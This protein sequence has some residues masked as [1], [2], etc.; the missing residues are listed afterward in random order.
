MKKIVL[1][2]FA[3]VITTALSAQIYLAKTCEISFFSASPLENIE[4]INKAAKP[5]IN[6]ATGDVQIKINISAFV[7]EKPLM[8]EHFNENY[9]ESEKFPTAMFYGKINEPVDWKKDG[10]TKVTVT[11]K[12]TIHG[13]EKERTLDGL[14]SVKGDQV[15]I[16]SKFMVH[17]ADH[18]VKVPSL[19]VQ[20]IAEDVQ[21]KINA[22]LEPYK[23]K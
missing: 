13:V 5:M 23:K 4:A 2:A 21:V 8:Q 9:M 11:G 16:S 6:T 22:T 18:G 15:T 17:I 20:N 12:L 14:V 19:Y 7:F 3:A 10:E 1:S